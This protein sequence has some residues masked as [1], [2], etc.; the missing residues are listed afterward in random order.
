MIGWKAVILCGVFV[1]S[2]FAHLFFISLLV[3]SLALLSFCSSYFKC[4][5]KRFGTLSLSISLSCPRYW[6]L[7]VVH[8]YQ[9]VKRVYV[10][11]TRMSPAFC[12]KIIIKIHLFTSMKS[13]EC[14]Q[15]KTNTQPFLPF[16]LQFTNHSV[17]GW[18]DEWSKLKVLLVLL[19]NVTLV[20]INV[21]MCHTHHYY[22]LFCFL[23]PVWS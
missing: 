14:A 7:C 20:S 11:K 5:K 12:W 6:C 23:L 2:I 4:F 1:L 13:R 8:F 17:I 19:T 21:Q 22:S 10:T 16:V 18:V 3:F 15:K 9:H